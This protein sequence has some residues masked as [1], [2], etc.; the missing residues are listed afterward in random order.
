MAPRILTPGTM[1][2][3]RYQ[4]GDVIG[5][6]DLSVVHAA[7]DS[8]NSAQ[9]ALKVFDA[10]V[11][12]RAATLSEYQSQARQ[13]SGLGV[14]GIA[15]AYDFGIDANTGLAFSTAERI[16][17]ASLDRRVAAQGPLG[18]AELSR[19]I[20]VLARALDAAHAARL[21][22]RDLKPQNVFISPD[23]PEWVRL[24][25]FGMSAVRR[26]APEALGWGGPPGYTPPDAVDAHATGTPGVD[27]FALGVIAF[28]ALTRG[29][30]FRSLRTPGFDPNAHW[31]ELNQP[32][33]PISGRAKEIGVALDPA[34]D[35]WFG[36]ALAL[37]PQ[38]R[39]RSAG[40]MARE[41]SAIADQVSAKGGGGP[42]SMRG[43]AAAIAQ[44]LVFQ[45]EPSP[46]SLGLGGTVPL[47]VS[48]PVA[49]VATGAAASAVTAGTGPR[50]PPNLLSTPDDEL[51]GVPKKSSKAPLFIGLGVLVLA[52]LAAASY[53]VASKAREG[54]SAEPAG[55]ASAA[56]SAPA[57]SASAVPSGASRARFSC[58]PEA[59][60]WIVCDSKN[61][62]NF[63]QE[64]EMTPGNHDCSASKLG[65][66]SKS[67]SFTAVP[68]QVVEVVFDLP[69]LPAS[70]Q[71]KAAAA[72]S[73]SSAT[74]AAAATPAP[75]T[76]TTPAAKATTAPGAKA[77]TKEAAAKPSATKKKKCSTFLGCK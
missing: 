69:P 24:T 12:A 73:A 62:T 10:S 35:P 22:H 76:A 15:R 74:P 32:L 18:V 6:S 3:G 27:L 71:Q 55:S 42:R 17:W 51:A 45:P 70:A 29:T 60:E 64:V 67:L 30:P 50:L 59:C 49:G 57:P 16:N 38:E 37:A 54:A 14:E 66:G 77:T 52:G 75:K 9:V 5:E 43:I 31:T 11:K 4:V 68:G 48:S 44:P 72:A 34:F 58:K 26:G 61:L 41:L 33:F 7:T 19:A 13:A 40:E 56:A 65:L 53:V 20:A 23:N 8:R 39:F 1:L 21:L 46:A 2:S 36:R 28:F 25:D 63:E 47:G